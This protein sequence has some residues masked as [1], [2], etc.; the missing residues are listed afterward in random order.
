MNLPSTPPFAIRARLLTPLDAGG[1]RHE[2]DGLIVVDEA[3]PDHVRRRRRRATRRG[4]P[5]H[6]PPPVGR[7]ARDGRPPRPP[8]A[9]AERRRRVRARPPDLAR[10]GHLPDRA[11]VVRSGGRRAT[12]AGHLRGLRRGRHDHRPRL[13]R[14]LRG[15]DGRR[16]PG[17]RGERHPGHPRQGDDGPRDLRPDH[18][19]VDD[20]RALLA[21]VSRP[22]RALAR[23]GRWTAAATRS[24]RASRS[25]CSAEM[26]RE[27]AALAASTGAW[28]QTHVS[29]DPFEIAEVARLHPEAQRLRRRL[30]PRRRP[31][32]EDRPRPRHP[33]LRPR[34]RAARSR[35][36]RTSRTARPP[37]CSSG[38]GSCRWRAIA[39]PACRWASDRMSSGGPEPRSSRSCGSAPTPQ[40]AQAV[41][42]RRRMAPS[43]IRSTGSGWAR[44]RGREALGLDDVIG[45]LETGKEADLI[46][47]DRR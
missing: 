41:D 10:P 8:A 30:R 33:P 6:R 9:G 38:R 47:V 21:R 28:W 25:R 39:R 11:V 22:D 1:T 15:R 32:G 13:R 18:R 36:A 31:R 37:T 35:P 2:A 20:P 16:L 14:R 29:E 19:A 44:S 34:A 5:G 45:S 3:G 23:R 42:G 43:S 24:R 40:M 27:S 12:R 26:L 17:S 7:H 4:R 46:A